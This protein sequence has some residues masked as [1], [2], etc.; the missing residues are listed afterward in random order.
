MA[1]KP[2]ATV[3]AKEKGGKVEIFLH[4]PQ[5][6]RDARTGHFVPKG[7]AEQTIRRVKEICERSGSDVN[8][9]EE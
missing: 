1:D 9:K 7:E 4:D 5:S 8:V 3:V 6:G 2:K